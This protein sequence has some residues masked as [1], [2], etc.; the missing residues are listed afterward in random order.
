MGHEREEMAGESDVG[1]QT[2]HRVAGRVNVGGAGGGGDWSWL[3][4]FMMSISG[5]RQRS[6]MAGGFAPKPDSRLLLCHPGF[7]FD[8]PK[9]KGNL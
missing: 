5:W 9:S 7:G 2:G 4:S 8:H 6:S 1:G 3:S